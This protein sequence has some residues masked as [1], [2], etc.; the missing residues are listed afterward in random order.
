MWYVYI[1]RNDKNKRFYIGATKDIAR[2]IKEH[3][4]SKERSVT[5]FGKYELIYSEE[6]A[7]FQQV[8]QREQQI[9]SYKSGNAFKKLFREK[10]GLIIQ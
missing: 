10:A 5:H 4:R 1:L 6:Y 2:R 8:R 3:N 7:T 9:K